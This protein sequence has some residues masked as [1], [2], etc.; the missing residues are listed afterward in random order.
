[1]T[2]ARLETR[3]KGGH[4]RAQG[5]RA[6]SAA[7]RLSQAETIDAARARLWQSLG[8]KPT[9]A[10]IADE[11]GLGVRTVRRVRAWQRKG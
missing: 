6:D 9:Y 10:E 8:R 11:I 1:M 3:R 4:A 2:E 7:L 5:Q